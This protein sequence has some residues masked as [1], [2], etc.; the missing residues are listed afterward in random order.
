MNILSRID[1]V[2]IILPYYTEFKPCAKR[3][4]LMINKKSNKLLKDY[5]KLLNILYARK[6]EDSRGVL[7]RSHLK[8]EHFDYLSSL[9]IGENLTLY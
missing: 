3:I 6:Y 8:Q 9:M 7:N 1:T 5:P 2:S 4:L